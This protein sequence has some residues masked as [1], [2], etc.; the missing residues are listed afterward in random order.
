ME[1]LYGSLPLHVPIC[2]LV[3][4]IGAQGVDFRVGIRDSL[5]VD[6]EVFVYQFPPSSE[7]AERSI[8]GFGCFQGYPFS[9]IFIHLFEL[10]KG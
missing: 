4:Q 8:E 7:L 10:L 9:A 6:R 5:L 2:R 3:F 1:S